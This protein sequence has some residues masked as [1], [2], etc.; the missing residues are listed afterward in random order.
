MITMYMMVFHILKSE[1]PKNDKIQQTIIWFMT[2][3]INQFKS[4]RHFSTIRLY[5]IL[6]CKEPL[7]NILRKSYVLAL[8]LVSPVPTVET[9]KLHW[10][11]IWLTDFDFISMEGPFHGNIKKGP[12]YSCKFVKYVLP[13]ACFL[14][15]FL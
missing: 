6:R 5:C 2:I 13:E 1:I 12:V 14:F 7:R 15:Y 9:H 8:D 4:N 11:F 10:I 3:R